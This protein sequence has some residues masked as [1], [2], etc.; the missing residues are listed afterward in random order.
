MH[1]SIFTSQSQKKQIPLRAIIEIV[2]GELCVYPLPDNDS[3]EKLILDEL[4]SIRD[5]FSR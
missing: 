4:L 1:E 3:D 5:G 2:G